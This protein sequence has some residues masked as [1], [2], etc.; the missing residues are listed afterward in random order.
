MLNNDY[1]ISHFTTVSFGND[2]RLLQEGKLHS[3]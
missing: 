3:R 2:I 1:D